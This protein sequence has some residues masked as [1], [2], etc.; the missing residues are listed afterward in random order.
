MLARSF[1]IKSSS[2]LLVT[3]TSIKAWSSW[4]LGRIRPLILELFALEWRKFHTF[5]LESLWSQLVSLDQILCVAALG[6]GKGCKRFWGRLDHSGEWSLPFG[7][8]VLKWDLTLAHWTQESDRCPFGYLYSQ[9]IKIECIRRCILS[10]YTGIGT[11]HDQ[12]KKGIDKWKTGLC[13]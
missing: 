12:Q 1:F 3:R 8:L 7:L 10:I 13:K 5:E 6:W 9:D 4:I 2:K 11:W